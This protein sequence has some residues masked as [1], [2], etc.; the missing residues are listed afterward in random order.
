MSLDSTRLI[1]F[2][3]LSVFISSENYDRVER[4][5]RTGSRMYG[6]LRKTSSSANPAL[7]FVD[8]AESLIDLVSSYCK[9]QQAR[10]RTKQLEMRNDALRKEI[11]NIK[12]VLEVEEVAALNRHGLEARARIGQMVQAVEALKRIGSLLHE[13]SANLRDFRLQGIGSRETHRRLG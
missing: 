9:Y 12:R 2:K 10:E 11:A 1:G 5:Y 3:V 6:L 8:A 13:V 4:V 7:A